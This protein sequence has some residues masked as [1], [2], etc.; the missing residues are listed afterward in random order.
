MFAAIEKQLALNGQWLLGISMI[1]LWA[2]SPLGGQSALRLLQV[3]PLVANSTI[4]VRYMPSAASIS[5]AM[6]GDDVETTMWPSFGPL[7]MTALISYRRQK[8]SAQDIFGN[9]RVPSLDTMLQSSDFVGNVSWQTVDYGADVPYSSLLGVP[10]VGVPATGNVS[11]AM[12]SRYYTID[13]VSSTVIYAGYWLSNSSQGQ[14]FDVQIIDSHIDDFNEPMVLFNLSSVNDREASSDTGISVLVCSAAPRDI[15]SAVLCV[16]GGCHVTAQ[17]NLTIDFDL[18]FNYELS[19]I[20]F[21]LKFLPTVAAGLRSGSL[22]Q[23][24]LTELWIQQPDDILASMSNRDFAN[25]SAVPL[26]T[27]SR[28]LELAFNTLFVAS[29]G[30][31]YLAGNLSTDLS[32]YDN[33]SYIGPYMPAISFNTSQAVVTSKDGEQYDC[34]MV[35]AGLLFAISSLLLV[36]GVASIVLMRST[37]APDILGYASSCTKDNPFIAV[38]EPSYLNGLER[39]KALKDLQVILGDV[40]G[41]RE[42]GHV[43]LAAIIEA[44]PLRKDR[45]YS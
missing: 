27:L 18:W 29:Y 8:D 20:C 31:Q 41:H 45:T 9:V 14:T 16:D 30:A 34:D 36:A 19:E 15:E 33:V 35:F 17:R 37:L 40:Q 28:N 44:V 4:D 11:F 26:P 23:S 7:Y 6:A 22:T 1:L 43:A 2:L 25:L 12:N 38:S 42:T 3:A 21:A 13:C 24:S 32:A 10:V 39:S 5:T